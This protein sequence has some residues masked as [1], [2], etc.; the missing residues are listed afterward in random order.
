MDSSSW[1]HLPSVQESV[2]DLVNTV[3]E[4]CPA[5]TNDLANASTTSQ[6]VCVALRGLEERHRRGAQY[7]PN[8]DALF[9]RTAGMMD[10]LEK[11]LQDHISGETGS[12]MAWHA[13]ESETVKNLTSVFEIFGKTAGLIILYNE[14]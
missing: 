4:Q 13:L 5:A 6:K 3:V 8:V 2:A 9:R 14:T 1:A 10:I 11:V 7:L 12:V